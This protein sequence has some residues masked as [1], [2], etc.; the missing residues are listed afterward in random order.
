MKNI[1]N[2]NE[3]ISLDQNLR[4]NR[5]A[6]VFPM[7]FF[8]LG[9]AGMFFG[10]QID[11]HDY[12]CYLIAI[13]GLLTTI[14]SLSSLFCQSQNII[15]NKTNETLYKHKLYF[16]ANEE[17]TV[18]NLLKKGDINSLL[19]LS[20]KCGPILTIIYSTTNKNYYIAQIFKFVPYEYIPYQDPIIFNQ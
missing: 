1:L 18:S 11:T 2:S 19:D 4:P 6:V 17:S 14:I 3:L 15:N 8:M 10:M 16:H 7:I 9:V 20:C 13:T 5:R 12:I